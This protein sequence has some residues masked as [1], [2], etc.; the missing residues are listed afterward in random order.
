[1]RAKDWQKIC[2]PFLLE[3]LLT[4]VRRKWQEFLHYC[5]REPSVLAFLCQNA[6]AKSEFVTLCENIGGAGADS[7]R[8]H[9]GF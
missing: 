3:I 2:S 8:A 1:V 4:G 5:L 9:S 7:F 6:N